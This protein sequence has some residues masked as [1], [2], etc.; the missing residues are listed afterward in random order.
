MVSCRPVEMLS[1]FATA[2]PRPFALL[3]IFTELTLIASELVEMSA[4][5]AILF[6]DI[7]SLLVLIAELL[8]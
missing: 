2:A 7:A 8:A 5:A 6:V 4:S 1:T 3:I